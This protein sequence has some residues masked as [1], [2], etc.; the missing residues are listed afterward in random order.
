MLVCVCVA[1]GGGVPVNNITQKVFKQSTSFSVEAFHL[2][3]GWRDPILRK[4]VHAEGWACGGGG[5]AKFWPND[6]R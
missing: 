6:K 3:Q 4:I 1:G 5:A 2:A